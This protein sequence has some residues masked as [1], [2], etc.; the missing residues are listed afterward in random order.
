MP[1]ISL[2]AEKLFTW[3]GM[4][5]TNA[6]LTTWIVMILLTVL[7]FAATRRIS[8]IPSNPQLI[9]EMLIGGLYDFFGSVTG[10]HIKQFFPLL[11]SIFLFVIVA[12]WVGLLPGV[13]TIG[14]FHESGHEAEAVHEEDAGIPGTDVHEEVVLVNTDEHAEEV[15]EPTHAEEIAIAEPTHEE[16]EA[17]APAFTPLLRGATAD[18][19]TTMALAIIAVLGIQYFGFRTLGVGYGSKF[20]NLKGPIDFFLGILELVSEISRIISFAFRLFGN[21]FA[22]EVLLAVIA[23]LMPFLLPLPFLMLELFVGFIQALVFSMLTAVFLNVAVS[24]GEGEHH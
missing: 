13:G 9:A 2:A 3:G 10:K 14:F 15:S 23:F 8:K 24:H 1:H 5:I 6:L 17:H 7:S 12:N 16:E 21:I 11:A 19:N 20:F 4:P 22:G 18:L